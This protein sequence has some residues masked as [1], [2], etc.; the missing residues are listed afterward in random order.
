MVCGQHMNRYN[1]VV[2]LYEIIEKSLFVRLTCSDLLFV[3]AFSTSSLMSPGENNK[4]LM[5]IF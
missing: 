2:L 3:N 5:L 4:Y 1:F